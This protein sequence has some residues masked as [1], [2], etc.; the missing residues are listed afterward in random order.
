[1]SLEPNQDKVHSLI[2]LIYD[3][4]GDPGVWQAFLTEFGHCMQ[5]SSVG[6]IVI[7][8]SLGVNQINENFNVDPYYLKSF[9][10][11]YGAI[12]PWTA[13]EKAH[14]WSAGRVLEG[15]ELISDQEMLKTEFYNGFS[16]PQGWFS[17]IGTALSISE[18]G[19]SYLT[20]ARK[21]EIDPDE[22]RPLFSTL[23]PHL[24]TAM[25]LHK[26]IARLEASVAALVDSL[27][28]LSSG[29]IIV[30]SQGKVLVMNRSAETLSLAIMG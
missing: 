3:A 27:D 13:P 28:L 1:M 15:R 8:G 18:Y 4:A 22:G 7:D 16:K 29:V 24:Q 10:Q 12:N 23:V 17:T 19:G 14:L 26:Q 25:G 2:R 21:R 11:Y 20:A 5:A 30:D 6:L 9:S